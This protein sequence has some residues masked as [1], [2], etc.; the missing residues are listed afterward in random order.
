MTHEYHFRMAGGIT[1][2]TGK[3]DPPRIIIVE[4]LKRSVVHD[5][6]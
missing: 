1:A 2:G 5:M 4:E 6:A 3:S